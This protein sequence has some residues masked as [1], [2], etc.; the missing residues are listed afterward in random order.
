MAE[1]QDAVTRIMD[2]KRSVEALRERTESIV[3]ELER[4]ATHYVEEGRQTIGRVRRAV[5]VPAQL[6]AH[7]MA[8]AGALVAMAASVFFAAWSH[9]SR[10]LATE[11]MLRR[12]PTTRALAGEL[13]R[14]HRSVTGAVTRTGLIG[15]AV[16]L[17][18]LLLLNRLNATRPEG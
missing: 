16:L 5:D 7:P 18:G 17:G 10:R 8:L 2:A 11:R 13:L 14:T 1:E 3:A 12:S 4:R 6:R 15:A 9:R